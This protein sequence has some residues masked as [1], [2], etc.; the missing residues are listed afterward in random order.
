MT[1]TINFNMKWINDTVNSY[2]NTDYNK[3]KYQII[4]KYPKTAGR[5]N[6]S[7]LMWTQT[8]SQQN[9]ENMDNYIHA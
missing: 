3:G 8:C 9:Q 7:I 1:Q 6:L 5:G 4:I 2:L